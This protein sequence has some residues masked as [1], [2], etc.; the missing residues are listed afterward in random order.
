MELLR[1]SM[2][3]VRFQHI[4]IS[5]DRVVAAR[6]NKQAVKAITFVASGA[7]RGFYLDLNEVA[8]RKAVE[9]HRALKQALHDAGIPLVPLLLVQAATSAWT[10]ARVK[11]LLLGRLKFPEAAVG[12]H[13]ADEPDPDVQAL[14]Q[15]PNIRSADLQDGC[16]NGVR[17]STCQHV[18][19]AAAGS[20]CGLW[21]AGDRKDHA[22]APV[23]A[24]A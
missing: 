18:V 4:S 15:D 21:L 2:D 11:A 22:R 9:Q 23:A 5:R 3:I 19:C 14:A 10:P 13:T 7:S 17:C 24:I 8:L 6:L 12:V 16:G 1:R 20:G